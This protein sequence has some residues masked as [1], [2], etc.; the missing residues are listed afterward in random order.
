M[1]DVDDSV[2]YNSRHN[3]LDKTHVE[4]CIPKIEIIKSCIARRFLVRTSQKGRSDGYG[5]CLAFQ[6]A[7]HPLVREVKFT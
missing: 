6:S 5:L 3:T 4:L 1:T 7:P 2:N